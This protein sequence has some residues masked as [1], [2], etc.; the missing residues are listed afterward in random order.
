MGGLSPSN[1]VAFC[2][3][4]Q[5]RDPLCLSPACTADHRTLLRSPSPRGQREECGDTKTRGRRSGGSTQGPCEAGEP[6]APLPLTPNSARAGGGL[7]DAVRAPCLGFHGPRLPSR[8]PSSPTSPPHAGTHSHAAQHAS[9]LLPR[10]AQQFSAR[11]WDGGHRPSMRGQ[12][13][14]PSPLASQPPGGRAC[15][16]KVE[17][18][19]AGAG[20]QESGETPQGL[21]FP[22]ASFQAPHGAGGDKVPGSGP[23]CRLLAL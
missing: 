20:R 4:P 18:C 1:S 16:W 7:R 5:S 17:G 11:P 13:G 21:P 9:G 23:P 6:P 22:Q 2:H 19:E 14:E 10:A 15:R 8:R 12:N 3:G